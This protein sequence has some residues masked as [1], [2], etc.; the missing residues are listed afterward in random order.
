MLL[1]LLVQSRKRNSLG[2]TPHAYDYFNK[3]WAEYQQ[4]FGSL[5]SDYW[6]GLETLSL[7]TELEDWILR[8]IILNLLNKDTICTINNLFIFKWLIFFIFK[9]NFRFH[10]RTGTIKFMLLTTIQ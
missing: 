4:G 9:N 5:E 2:Q 6:M 8:V 10:Y 3:T 1:G 7:V